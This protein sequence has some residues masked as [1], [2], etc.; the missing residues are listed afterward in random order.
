MSEGKPHKLW[1]LPTR[2]FHWLLVIAIPLAW[3]SA[4]QSRY[5]LHEWLGYGLLVL[6]S[7]RIVWGF[8][9]SRHSLFSDFLVGPLRVLSYLRSERASSVGHN[10][11]GGWSV[12]ILLS[13]ILLQVI[14]GLFN[15]DEILFSGPLYRLIDTDLQVTMAIV[16]DLA[17]DLLLALIVLHIAA[18]LYHQFKLKEKIIQ[19]M[20]KGSAP[21]KEGRA[22]PVSPWRAAAVAL[23]LAAALWFG[24]SQVPQPVS[25]W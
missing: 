25:I 22:A 7:S 11:L 23:L 10:P 2:V 24:L 16:H 15:S 13:L 3:W 12:L 19:A 9:G 4:E 5:D 18:V 14:S 20:I 17:F 21:G 8:I 6:I 1:D